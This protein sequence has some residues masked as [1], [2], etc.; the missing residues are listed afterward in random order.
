MSNRNFITFR[1]ALNTS[2]IFEELKQVTPLQ[3][4]ICDIRDPYRSDLNNLVARILIKFFGLAT[5]PKEVSVVQVYR[6]TFLN[7]LTRS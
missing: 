6:K 5:L 2:E 7:A 4:I 1:T 3:H